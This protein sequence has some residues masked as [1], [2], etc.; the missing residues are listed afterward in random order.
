MCSAPVV[1]FIG[2]NNAA[3]TTGWSVTVS[4]IDFGSLDT[5]P[6]TRL[7]VSN[8]LTAAW[9]SSTSLVCFTTPGEGVEKDAAMTVAGVVGTRTKTFSYDGGGR[10]V[11]C[12]CACSPGPV[13]GNAGR[14]CNGSTSLSTL[15]GLL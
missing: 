1:S 6:T 11:L 13:I 2:E 10:R 4:G 7:G 5:T 14:D 15:H 9:A 12:S 3:T 8:C